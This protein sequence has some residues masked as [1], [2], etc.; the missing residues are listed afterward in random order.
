MTGIREKATGSREVSEQ[1][2]EVRP[3][4]QTTLVASDAQGRARSGNDTQPDPPYLYDRPSLV[5]DPLETSSVYTP[6]RKGGRS[7]TTSTTL[8][9]YPSRVHARAF[10]AGGSTGKDERITQTEDVTLDLESY[11]PLNDPTFMLDIDSDGE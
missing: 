8:E 4:T 11:G 5:F 9:E 2:W 3:A 6:I 1:D 7:S 10:A